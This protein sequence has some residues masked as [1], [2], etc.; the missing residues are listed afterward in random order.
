MALLPPYLSWKANQDT[1]LLSGVP[2]TM[3]NG[4]YVDS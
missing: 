3:K 1:G 2:T 4:A